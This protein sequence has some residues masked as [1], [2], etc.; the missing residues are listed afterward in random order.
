MD[1]GE[2]ATYRDYLDHYRRVI[3]RQCADL[4]PEQLVTRAVAPST[5]S[6]LGLLRHMAY[7]E[8]TWFQ[9]ALQDHTDEPR[10]FTDPADPD[11]EFNAITG[12]PAE[13][14]E[15]YAA[16]R[17]QIARADAWLETQSD[18]SMAEELALN[19]DGRTG[20]KRE[21]LVHLIEEYARHAGHADLLRERID[22]RTGL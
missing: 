16:W 12:T 15:A 2:L 17:D 8:Q 10:L 9:R 3:E 11:H 21:V 5:L 13:V 19:R 6:L 1:S 4:T 20:T 22:G 7:V 18:E 14:E